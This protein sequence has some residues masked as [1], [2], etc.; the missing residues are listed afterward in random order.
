MHRGLALVVS[1]QRSEA[2]AS[3]GLK[4]RTN[5]ELKKDTGGGSVCV[6]KGV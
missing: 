4:H 5:C 3:F 2:V 6:R 1:S